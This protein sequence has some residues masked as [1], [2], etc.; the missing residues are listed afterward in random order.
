VVA[1]DRVG[2]EQRLAPAVQGVDE[3]EAGAAGAVEPGADL[4]GAV[5]VPDVGVQDGGE[6]VLVD[7]E[8]GGQTGEQG[9]QDVVAEQGFR[10]PGGVEHHQPLCT[11]DAERPSVALPVR[12]GREHAVPAGITGQYGRGRGLGADGTQPLQ[13]L[14]VRQHQRVRDGPPAFVEQPLGR[15]PENRSRRFRRLA[16]GCWVLGVG[17]WVLGV[18]CWVLGVPSLLVISD[19]V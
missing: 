1:D 9:G 17:C 3:G 16:A 2:G 8:F 7:G 10:V 19:T 12:A 6:T 11:S 14:G 18:G 15:Q 4:A 13:L 5:A